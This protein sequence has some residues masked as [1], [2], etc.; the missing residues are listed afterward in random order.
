MALVRNVSAIDISIRIFSG[1]ALIYVGF[2]ET[3]LIAT[4]AVRISFG[5]I[6]IV[7]LVVA[8]LRYC[9]L[10]ALAGINTYQKKS[11]LGEQQPSNQGQ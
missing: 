6:G 3:S 10:Y 9:P 2:I 5:V 7:N 8:I 1:L 11:E 4:P